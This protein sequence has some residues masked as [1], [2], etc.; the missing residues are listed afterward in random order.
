MTTT[1]VEAVPLRE[2]VA[3]E[4]RV[5]LTRRRMSAAHLGRKLG[6]SQTWVWRRLKGETAFDLDDLERIAELLGVAVAELLPPD[7]RTARVN[8]GAE[9]DT[10]N[11]PRD[12]RPPGGARRLVG[13]G[14]R[15]VTTPPGPRR[16]RRIPN[17]QPLPPAQI[18]A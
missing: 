14:D 15:S 3:E 12:N 18:A 1:P 6:V 11:R 5:L 10:P 7:M 4:I 8:N 9:S 2:R 17:P 16:P 13:R